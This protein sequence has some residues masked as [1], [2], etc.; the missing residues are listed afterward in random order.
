MYPDARLKDAYI[1]WNATNCCGRTVDLTVTEQF[2]SSLANKAHTRLKSAQ[3]PHG[4][5]SRH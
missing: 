5:G 1:E 2:A 3:K 4:T